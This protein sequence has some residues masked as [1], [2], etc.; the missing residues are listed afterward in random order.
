LSNPSSSR[1]RLFALAIG[2]FL[3]RQQRERMLLRLN[4]VYA[5]PPARSEKRLLNNM[6]SK[7]RSTV[8]ERW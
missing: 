4:E 8:K 6:K 5:N 2:A 7:F 3:D 1:R